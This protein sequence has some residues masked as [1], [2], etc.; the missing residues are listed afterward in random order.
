MGCQVFGQSLFI[1]PPQVWCIL[2]K[3][4]FFKKNLSLREQVSVACKKKPLALLNFLAENR[5]YADGNISTCRI[6]E[7]HGEMDPE[8][9]IV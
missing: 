4:K 6:R 3:F 7:W 5:H 2:K 9:I 8:S 1:F